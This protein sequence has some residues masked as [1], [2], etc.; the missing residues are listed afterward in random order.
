MVLAFVR[1]DHEVNEVKV[2]NTIGVNEVEMA[3]ESLLV[4]AGSLRRLYGSVGIDP[5]KTIVIVDSTFHNLCCGADEEGFR[6]V[7]VNPQCLLL[8]C[9]WICRLVPSPLRW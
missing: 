3:D 7:N 1:G 9:C 2:V 8:L 5:E 4:E 6:L